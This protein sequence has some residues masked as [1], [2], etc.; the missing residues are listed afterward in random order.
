MSENEFDNNE[1][2][3]STQTVEREEN[4]QSDKVRAAEASV[5]HCMSF[6]EPEEAEA[7]LNEHVLSSD[8]WKSMDYYLEEVNIE[9]LDDSSD[10]EINIHRTGTSTTIK[11]S[12][13]G[14][15]EFF[16]LSA[17]A[18][19][20]IDPDK[21]SEGKEYAGTMLALAENFLGDDS[22][23][24]LLEAYEAHGVE[25]EVPE[26]EATEEEEEEEDLPF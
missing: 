21:A 26:S 18:S 2:E 19:Q 3:G 9:L 15:K 16:I 8:W 1:N 17:L 25:Y 12:K 10:G 7:W 5:F 22:H 11:V 23:E 6:D 24:E 13:L 20:V 14:L 4:Y